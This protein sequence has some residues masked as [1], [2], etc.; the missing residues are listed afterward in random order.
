MLKAI[1]DL[2]KVGVYSCALI[3]KRK[4]WPKGVPG[5]AM[6]S[7]FDADGVNVGDC[8]A[9]QGMMEG[10]TYNLWEMKE[11]QTNL[12]GWPVIGGMR[13]GSRF[14]GGLNIHAHL[15]DIFCISMQ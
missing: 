15:T 10:T 3:K 13:G 8:H 7:F 11:P 5:E 4:Y 1:C 12:A 9:I 14:I 6:Q 2:Q